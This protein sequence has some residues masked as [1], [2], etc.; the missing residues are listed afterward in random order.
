MS[1]EKKWDLETIH[2]EVNVANSRK[3]FGGHRKLLEVNYL[4]M[5]LLNLL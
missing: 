5:H 4:T 1:A 3:R 2:D